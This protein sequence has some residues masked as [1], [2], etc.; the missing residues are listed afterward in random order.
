MKKI[1]AYALSV[2]LCIMAFIA[3]INGLNRGCVL[4]SGISFSIN[5]LV[6]FSERDLAVKV[7]G[8]LLIILAVISGFILSPLIPVL[9]SFVIL[10]G[11]K[12]FL[13][14]NG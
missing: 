9:A 1:I 7:I 6:D 13:R 10:M 2:A 8:Y 3:L 12:L 5:C 11:L 4:F 14:V